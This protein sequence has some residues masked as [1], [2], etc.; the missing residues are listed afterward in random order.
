META[1][2]VPFALWASLLAGLVTTAGIY[3]V[4]N[5]G[6]WGRKNAVYFACFAAG[7]LIAVSF[8]HLIPTSL[9]LSRQGPIFMLTGYLLMHFLN[10][11]L[12]TQVCD[13]VTSV[14][15]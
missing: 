7:V 9:E 8:L 6:D 14:S 12:T 3:T 10:R 4:R 13:K 15:A 11:S 1:P 5:F 2:L